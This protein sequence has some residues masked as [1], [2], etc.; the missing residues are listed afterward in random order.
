MGPAG[1]ELP[2][3]QRGAAGCRSSVARP[4]LSNMKATHLL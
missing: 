2:S 4:S 3:T 1:C